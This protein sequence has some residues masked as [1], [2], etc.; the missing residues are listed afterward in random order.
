[1][2][3]M[4]TEGMREEAQ[5]YRDWK[6]DGRDGGTEVAARRASQI[7]S[8]NELSDDTIVEMSAWFARH[9]VDKKLRGLALARRVTLLQAVS[10]GLPGAETLARLFLIA[11]LNLWTAQLTKRPGQNPT[12]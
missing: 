11:L 12:N 5:R 2:P 6:K 8:G 1:M 7:L 3:A 9:E 10:P 4:P